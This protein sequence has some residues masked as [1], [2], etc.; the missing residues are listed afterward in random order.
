VAG[1]LNHIRVTMTAHHVQTDVLWQMSVSTHL[2]MAFSCCSCSGVRRVPSRSAP[3]VVFGHLLPGFSGGSPLQVAASASLRS[4]SARGKPLHNYWRWSPAQN[5]TSCTCCRPS[6]LP[7]A[8][9]RDYAHVGMA[10]MCSRIGDL[11]AS[12]R[13]PCQETKKQ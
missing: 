13:T 11:N 10:G 12:V 7:S 1:V 8:W 2:Q 9:H 6:Y 5:F 3:S 4:S